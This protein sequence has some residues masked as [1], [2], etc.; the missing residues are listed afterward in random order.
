MV[1]DIATGDSN[2]THGT[3]MGTSEVSNG[4]RISLIEDVRERLT[5][6]EPVTDDDT[7]VF[8][9]ADGRVY[10]ELAR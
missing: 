7:V 1:D 6:D 4:Y 2:R 3:V 8:Y 9:E 10:V 5:A